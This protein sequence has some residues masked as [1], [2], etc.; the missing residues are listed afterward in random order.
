MI[1]ADSMSVIIYFWTS[2]ASR[3]NR[4]EAFARALTPPPDF[5]WAKDPCKAN[6]RDQT[7]VINCPLPASRTLIGYNIIPGETKNEGLPDRYTRK[8]LQYSILV[9]Q[10]KKSFNM[11]KISVVEFCSCFHVSFH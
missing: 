5:C 2:L 7:M 8:L 4:P 6:F 11:N 1:Q 10:Y 3:R 9:A